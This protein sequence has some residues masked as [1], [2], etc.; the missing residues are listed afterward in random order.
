MQLG[1]DKNQTS[2][3]IVLLQRVNNLILYMLK[4]IDFLCQQ[5]QNENFH[6]P[7]NYKYSLKPN[8]L[9]K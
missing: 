4:C 2:K 3:Q 6:H 1:T 7:L 5:I 9:N 8:I